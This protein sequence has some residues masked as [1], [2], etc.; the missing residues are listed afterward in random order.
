MTTIE[1]VKTTTTEQTA[2]KSKFAEQKAAKLLEDSPEVAKVVSK[3]ADGVNET[4]VDVAKQLEA[5]QAY[6]NIVKK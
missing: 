4:K 6:A 5:Y 3:V 1:P 2:F